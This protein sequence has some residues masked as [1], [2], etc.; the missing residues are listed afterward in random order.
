[1]LSETKM[2]P[3]TPVSGRPVT[4][5]KMSNISKDREGITK[6]CGLQ[7]FEKEG[8]QGWSASHGS[9]HLP[10]RKEGLSHP[11]GTL[12]ETRPSPG[13][14]HHPFEEGTTKAKGWKQNQTP[15]EQT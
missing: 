7:S 2:L 13:P 1:M 3:Q 5:Q 14:P 8:E 4:L 12:D 6:G 15:L 11:T 10:G 9:E